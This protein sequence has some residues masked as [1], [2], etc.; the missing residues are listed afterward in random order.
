MLRNYLKIAVRNL[1][2]YRAYSYINISGLAVGIACCLMILLYVFDELSYDDFHENTDRIYRINTDLKFGDTELAI[3]VTSDGMGPILKDD[4][5]EVEEYTRIYYYGGKKL[6]R[7]A[8]SSAE[9]NIETKAA[10]VDSTFFRVFT[11]PVI[12]GI[13]DKVLNEPNTVVITQSVAKKYFGTPYAAGRSIETD[14]NGGTFY[15]V[16]A[17]IYDMP[18]NSHFRFDFLFSMANC[19]YEW[20]NF[21][22]MNFHTYLLLKEGTD[23]R[24]FEKKFEE[25]NDKYAFPYARKFL[26]VNSRQEFERAGN[27]LKHTLIPLRDIHL[28]SKRSQEISPSGSI[29][30]IYIFSAVAFFILIIACINFMNLTTARSANRAREVGIRKVLGTDRKSLVYQFLTESIVMAF[31]AV[32]LAVLIVY[33]TLPYFNTLA[34][35]ELDPSKFSSITIISLIVLLSIL[36][37]GAAGMYPAFFLS[38]SMP[39]EIIKG[40]LSRGAKH[41]GIRS[42][43]VVFQFASSVVLIIGTIIIYEQLSFIQNKNLGY[44]K[45]QVLII[46][47]TYT[48][49]NIDAFKN[50]MLRVSG[51]LSGTISEFL[52]VPSARNFSAFYNEAEMVASSGLTMQRWSIDY[53][54]LNTLGIELIKGRNFSKEFGIDSS[55]LILNE[56]AVRQFGLKEP[57]DSKIYTWEAGGR[58]VEYHVIGVVKNFHFE[59]M[60]QDIGSLC[61][62]LDRSYGLISFRVNSADI[63]YI[64]SEAEKLWKS[65]NPGM[66]FRYRFLDESF[67][68]VYKAEQRIGVIALLFSSLAILVACLGLFA[69]ASFLAEQKR[70]E[71]GVRKVLGASVPSLLLL[72][73]KEFIKWVAIAN[74]IALPVA[75]YFMN[76]WLE[77]FAYR[78]TISWWVFILAAAITFIIAIATVSFQAVKAA[79]AN[80]VDSL[81]YE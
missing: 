11:Y 20:G 6:V 9:Y 4:Y 52:P 31:I 72:L 25:Y 50:E 79:L 64:L 12:T 13:T 32:I 40:K 68:D 58:V 3:P 55:A 2:K 54:Y 65:M 78:T 18:E 42:A 10:F 56:T 17:V 27:R 49:N 1:L 39:G 77:D 36:I 38:R 19:G 59:S 41:G 71:I 74:L 43:L 15:K 21:V 51:V 35:K 69:L 28:Y 23:Y 75:W 7:A 34:G 37:G 73:S 46:N 57:L 63:S 48:L 53:D 45:D 24:E 16:A 47:D 70:K 76:K 8:G 62:S 81:H 33:Y 26:Q 22:S 29:E 44:Q 66:P 5:P 67:N 60:H 80:P 30:Y 14:E 61:F